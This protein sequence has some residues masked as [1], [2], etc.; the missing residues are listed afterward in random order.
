VRSTRST[1][2][3]VVGQPAYALRAKEGSA[4]AY[5]EGEAGPWAEL[6]L[7]AQAETTTDPDETYAIDGPYVDGSANGGGSRLSWRLGSTAWSDK[8]LTIDADSSGLAIRLDLVGDGALRDV[9]L[10]GGRGALPNGRSG[11]FFSRRA[12]ATVLPAAP[13]DPQRVVLPA[14]A[15]IDATVSGG[16]EPGRPGWFF[17]P[18]PF[19]FGATRTPIDDPMR[20]PAGP[21]LGFGLDAPP[22]EQRFLGFGY[23]GGDAGF[24]F[25]LDYQ[26]QTRVDGSWTSPTIRIAPGDDPYALL[27]RYAHDLRGSG[28]VPTAPD[29]SADPGHEAPAW[30]REP[31]FCG[32]GAQCAAA[33]GD[34]RSIVEAPAYST[35]QHYDGWLDRLEANGIVPG[36]IV[37]DDG[38]AARYALPEPHSDRWPDLPGWIKARHVRGQR[39]L[40]WWKAWDTTGLPPD[41]SV[42]TPDGRPVAVDPNN[43]EATATIADGIRTML[44]PD[45]L[46][47]DGLKIDFTA[48]TP[49]GETLRHETGDWG[50][51]LLRRLLTVVRDAAVSVRPDALLIGQVPEPSL[52]PL[53]DM[54]RLNDM[55]RLD[56]PTPTV[57]VVPQMRYRAAIVR[58]ANPDHLIDTDDWCMP[59]LATWRDYAAVKPELGVPSLYYADRLDLTGESFTDSDY[60]LLR[61]TWSE[62]REREGLP[63]R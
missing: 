12:F 51:A 4:W 17:T 5:L 39:V 20:L 45:G 9:I 47:A 49:S 29:R 31:I 24:H 10:L 42:R 11:S 6:C 38:W 58:A 60:A 54:I 53:L 50:V 27:A 13:G 25:V 23:R 15:S 43:Q 19:W 40:L 55:L 28:P 16:G 46:G 44:D 14:E 18:A 62:Y 37:I 26:G 36:T 48:R 2:D 34:D 33:T 35:Q 59:D 57:S 7:F 63:A 52:A 21:W 30:W 8:R 1:A 22:E 3:V 56:D 41:L 61:R 32:W